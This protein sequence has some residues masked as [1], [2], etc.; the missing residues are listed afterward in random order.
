M[1]TPDTTLAY[2]AGMIDADGYI[3]ITR[4]KRGKYLYFA[5]QVGIAGTRREPHDLASSIWGGCVSRYVPKNAAHRPQF[6][7]SRV[8]RA[9]TEVIEAIYPFLLVKRE[10]AELALSLWEHLEDGRFEDP[11]PWYGPHYDPTA[12]SHAMREL[13]IGMNQSRNRVG[14]KLAGRTLDGRE[15]SQFPESTPSTS[16]TQL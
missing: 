10:H 12:E 1:F 16:E 4:S 13:M 7:W 5:P 8:G 6:Q 9:A 15:W 2:L 11:Y 14:K 3:S